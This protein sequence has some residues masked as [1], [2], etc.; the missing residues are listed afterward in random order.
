MTKF[1]DLI[2][3]F[4][5]ISISIFIIA[6]LL[7]KIKIDIEYPKY[8]DLKCI[9]IREGRYSPIKKVVLPDS[10]I[11]IKNLQ[12]TTLKATLNS[13]NFS[14][15]ENFKYKVGDTLY[16]KFLKKSRFY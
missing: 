1:L 8:Y 13:S 3:I 14:G 10:Y 11:V 6:M 16:F 15:F 2:L 12:D 4:F 7:L 9:V 5:Y